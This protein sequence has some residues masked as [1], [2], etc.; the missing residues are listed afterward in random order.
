MPVKPDTLEETVTALWYAIVGTNGDGVQERLKKL[1][2]RPRNRWLVAKDVILI[3]VP[4]VVLAHTLG[5]I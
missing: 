4:A 3:A 1:E 2:A 5:F